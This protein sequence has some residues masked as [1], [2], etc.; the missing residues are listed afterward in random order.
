MARIYLWIFLIVNAFMSVCTGGDNDIRE[1]EVFV[2]KEALSALPIPEGGLTH[3]AIIK[4]FIDMHAE[5]REVFFQQLANKADSLTLSNNQQIPRVEWAHFIEE[6]GSPNYRYTDIITENNTRNGCMGL[7]MSVHTHY[8]FAEQWPMLN[9]KSL[10]IPRQFASF[11][12][13]LDSMR[14]LDALCQSSQDNDDQ[15]KKI[16]ETTQQIDEHYRLLT[17]ALIIYP[18][19][20]FPNVHYGKTAA[21]WGMYLTA[22]IMFLD[23]VVFK[24]GNPGIE[25]LMIVAPLAYLGVTCFFYLYEKSLLTPRV[26]YHI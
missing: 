1:V 22:M 26:L 17:K 20:L 14:D 12:R 19:K 24:M 16:L 6:I 21:L 13:V 15:K 7:W 10:I 2:P 3:Q 9:L 5:D 4:S 8:P 11:I 25:L 18:D 23:T